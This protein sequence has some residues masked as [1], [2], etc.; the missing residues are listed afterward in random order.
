MTPVSPI[1]WTGVPTLQ[2]QVVPLPSWPIQLFPQAH[3]VPS[4]RSARLCRPPA[5]TWMTPVSPVTWTGVLLPFDPQLTA[6]C[7]S[8]V[9]HVTRAWAGGEP[10]TAVPARPTVSAA[11]PASRASRRDRCRTFIV[12][13]PSCPAEPDNM[14][15]NGKGCNSGPP[16]AWRARS[17]VVGQD[18]L[19]DGRAWSLQSR[20]WASP[21]AAP[22]PGRGTHRAAPAGQGGHLTDGGKSEQPDTPGAAAFQ[23]RCCRGPLTSQ[24]GQTSIA[25]CS[26]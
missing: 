8:T 12:L 7:R 16:T 24:A 1:T 14:A 13:P 5:A 2:K 21:P 11:Q 22:F 19:I 23:I 3:T 15:L 6:T 26:Q 9:G 20:V 25:C 10:A 18:R 4:E 17:H